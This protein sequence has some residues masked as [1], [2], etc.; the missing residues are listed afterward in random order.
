VSQYQNNKLMEDKIFN[1]DN[2]VFCSNVLFDING[3]TKVV[4]LTQQ[5]TKSRGF[6]SLILAG[7]PGKKLITKEKQE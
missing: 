3:V 2:F 1:D 7:L 4:S 6:K 5:D